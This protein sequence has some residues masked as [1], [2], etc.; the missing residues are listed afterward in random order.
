MFFPTVVGNHFAAWRV[1]VTAKHDAPWF[2]WRGWVIA[3]LL[4]VEPGNATALVQ[5]LLNKLDRLKVLPSE[6][7]AIRQQQL[8]RHEQARVVVDMVAFTPDRLKRRGRC[9]RQRSFQTAFLRVPWIMLPA[10]AFPIPHDKRSGNAA[11]S[12][13][14]PDHM[15]PSWLWTW[16]LELGHTL[17]GNAADDRRRRRGCWV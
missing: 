3:Q 11:D 5:N 6:R 9:C 2:I 1:L 15:E 4:R 17:S 13:G 8:L 10:A 16:I 12:A 14:E 7:R